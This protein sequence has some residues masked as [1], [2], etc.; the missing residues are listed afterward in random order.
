M[1]DGQ[2]F[3]CFL[4]LFLYF[5]LQCKILLFE[6]KYTVGLVL[7]YC[8]SIFRKRNDCHQV[9]SVSAMCNSD[10]LSLEYVLYRILQLDVFNLSQLNFINVLCFERFKRS[11][12]NLGKIVNL[13]ATF[14]TSCS[15]EHSKEIEELKC[16]RRLVAHIAINSYRI[17]SRNQLSSCAM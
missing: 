17:I 15:S 12:N 9:H 2:C 3:F 4:F 13:S 5:F 1:E 16:R 8:G 10:T 11:K 14:L 7:N 6:V